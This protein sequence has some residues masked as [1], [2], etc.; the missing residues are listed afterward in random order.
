MHF[1]QWSLNTLAAFW[2]LLVPKAGAT[3]PVVEASVKVRGHDVQIDPRSPGAAETAP[4]CNVP[5]MNEAIFVEKLKDIDDW[6]QGIMQRFRDNP[7]THK[8]FFSFVLKTNFPTVLPSHTS[9]NFVN[10]CDP[11]SCSLFR[12][13]LEG[14]SQEKYEHERAMA[15]YAATAITNFHNF[16]RSVGEAFESAS[17]HISGLLEELWHTFSW[18]DN[19]ALREKKKR[20]SRREKENSESL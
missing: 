18:D 15:V 12:D 4:M 13:I 1:A 14:E 2:T 17:N 5:E 11:V 3:V 6:M 8:T 10:D 7:G 9:C 16:Y 20:K 19:Y